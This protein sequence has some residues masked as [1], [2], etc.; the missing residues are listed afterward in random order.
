MRVL[1]ACEYSGRVR[2]AFRRRGHDA[3][4]CDLLECEGDA[5]WHLQQ[6]ATGLG[7][8]GVPFPMARGV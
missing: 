4:S 6:L 5:S 8:S 1:V 3:W 7:E 2:D